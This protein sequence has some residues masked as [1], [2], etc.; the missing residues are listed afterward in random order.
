M[1]ALYELNTQ[2][3]ESLLRT[4]RTVKVKVPRLGESSE[5]YV[6]D[7]AQFFCEDNRLSV[8]QTG[9]CVSALV[10]DNARTPTLTPSELQEV[11]DF[12][13]AFADTDQM[14][15]DAYAKYSAKS[16]TRRR[17]REV[18]ARGGLMRQRLTPRNPNSRFGRLVAHARAP[19]LM[20]IQEAEGLDEVAHESNL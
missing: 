4:C 3:A 1:A 13:A 19:P 11:I 20:A 10:I 8:S 12:V 17:G 7:H 5:D 16:A 9:Q 6:R 18:A 2:H 15:A 14:L